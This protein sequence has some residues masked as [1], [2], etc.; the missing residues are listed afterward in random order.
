MLNKNRAAALVEADPPGGQRSRH[1]RHRIQDAQACARSRLCEE[2][3]AW[4]EERIAKRKY[5]AQG[6]RL[7]E[8]LRLAGVPQD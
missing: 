4:I 3:E 5:L 7:Y 1:V 6:E 8:G 2:A